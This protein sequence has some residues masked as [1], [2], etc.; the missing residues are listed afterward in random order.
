MRAFSEETKLRDAWFSAAMFF[1]LGAE[2]ET[3][4]FPLCFVPCVTFL[5]VRP[6]GVAKTL[7]ELIILRPTEQSTFRRKKRRAHVQNNKKLR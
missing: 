6:R 4:F 5:F 3:L 7:G 2:A 1:E